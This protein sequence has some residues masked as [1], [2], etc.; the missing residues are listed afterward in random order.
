MRESARRATAFH[1][2]GHIVAAW[3]NGLIA[4]AI[5]TPDDL[6]V[7]CL[8]SPGGAR[9]TADQAAR[10]KSYGQYA[11]PTP[12]SQLGPSFMNNGMATPWQ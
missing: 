5:L 2:A 7:Y 1:D 8:G 4:E 11:Q 12:S 3:R 6:R 10:Y 9:A